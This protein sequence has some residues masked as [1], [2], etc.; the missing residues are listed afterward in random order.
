MISI[1]ALLL[2]LDIYNEEAIEQPKEDNSDSI[3][4]ELDYIYKF[5]K[6]PTTERLNYIF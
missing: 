4:A 2:I 5:Y 3:V 1:Q 6:D